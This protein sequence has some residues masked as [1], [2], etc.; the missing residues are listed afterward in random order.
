MITPAERESNGERESNAERE[1][2][3]NG[4]EVRKIEEKDKKRGRGKVRSSRGKR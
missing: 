2:N 4:A 3:D 1:S